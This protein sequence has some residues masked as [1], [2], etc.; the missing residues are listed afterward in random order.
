MVV[1]LDSSD[2]APVAPPAALP[3][4]AAW[5]GELIAAHAATLQRVAAAVVGPDLADDVVSVAFTVAW[6]QRA[7]FDAARGEERAWLVGITLNRCRELGRA[8]RRWRRRQHDALSRA[9]REQWSADHAEATIER[10]DAAQP[11]PAALPALARLPRDQRTVLLLVAHAGLT[12][13]EVPVPPDPPPPTVRSHLHR[14]R[15]ALTAALDLEG[16]TDA[17]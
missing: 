12:P 17:D 13:A 11:G 1:F 10:L 5:L 7:G 8:E 9:A 16:A 3:N 6:E 4:D 14:A 15:A 2:R